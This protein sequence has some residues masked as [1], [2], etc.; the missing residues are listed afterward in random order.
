MSYS[1]TPFEEY[2]RLLQNITFH[3]TPRETY[4]I[5]E[6][7]T[8]LL[9]LIVKRTHTLIN[10]FET[11][12]QVYRQPLSYVTYRLR[13]LFNRPV[14]INTGVLKISNIT[15]E[16]VIKTFVEYFK[17]YIVCPNCNSKDTQINKELIQYRFFCAA[18]HYFSFI[19]L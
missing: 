5:E 15:R 19:N 13:R 18:C 1:K 4:N 8:S 10:N 16:E 17:R 2:K 9:V 3:N 6:L 14:V 12:C 7:V 11:F